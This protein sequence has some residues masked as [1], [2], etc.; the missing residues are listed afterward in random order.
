MLDQ[1][2]TRDRA[3]SYGSAA[4]E[5]RIRGIIPMDYYRAFGLVDILLAFNAVGL[6]RESELYARTAK[7][8]S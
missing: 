3:P 7:G 1:L 4:G 2:E 8:V 5:G 6:K